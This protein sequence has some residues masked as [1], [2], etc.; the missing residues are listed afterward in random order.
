LKNNRVIFRI[1][2]SILDCRY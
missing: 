2:W 1:F